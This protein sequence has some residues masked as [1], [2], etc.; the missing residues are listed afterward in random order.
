MFATKELFASFLWFYYIS[1]ILSNK[2][3][4]PSN[5]F[6]NNTDKGDFKANHEAF[7]WRNYKT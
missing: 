2:K 3:K 6:I 5:N 1:A 4:I 7:A